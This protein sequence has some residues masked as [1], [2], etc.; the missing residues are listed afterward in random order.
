[1]AQYLTNHIER[2][3]N[4]QTG[5]TYTV[6]EADNEAIV[7]VTNASDITVTLPA[8]TVELPVGFYVDIRQGGAGQIT[9]AAGSG[10]TLY[11][12]PT[13]KTVDAAGAMVRATKVGT[14][15]WHLGGD[16]AAS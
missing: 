10:N 13:L 15:L 5:T 3:L 4:A 14:A 2:P 8:S 16:N 12:Q 9:V 11:G 1:L 6:T 7:T